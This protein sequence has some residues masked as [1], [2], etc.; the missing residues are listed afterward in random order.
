[1]DQEIK[2]LEEAGII[3]HLMSNWALPIL[4]MPK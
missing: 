1:M 2:Q 4:V 3:S